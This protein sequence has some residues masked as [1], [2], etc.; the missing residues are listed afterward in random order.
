MLYLPSEGKLF[1]P[2]H[3]TGYSRTQ[4]DRLIPL[5]DDDFPEEFMGVFT[6]GTSVTCLR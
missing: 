2:V 5:A 4:P 1:I 3:I 6:G